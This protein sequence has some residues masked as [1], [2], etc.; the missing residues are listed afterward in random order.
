[1]SNRRAGEEKNVNIEHRL[2]ESHNKNILFRDPTG[3][4]KRTAEEPPREVGFVEA[5]RRIRNRGGR[6]V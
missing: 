1:M 2:I 3:S 5:K 6:G 4:T